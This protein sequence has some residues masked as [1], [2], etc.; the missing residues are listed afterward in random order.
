MQRVPI[1]DD[2]PGLALKQ[3]VVLERELGVP[4]VSIFYDGSG[5]PN[6]VLVPHLHYLV[7]RTASRTG[8]RAE[9]GGG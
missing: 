2:L 8:R 9:T 6:R 1:A 7:E 5:D 4:V 3:L